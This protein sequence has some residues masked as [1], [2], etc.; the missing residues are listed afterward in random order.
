MATEERASTGIP[1]L[2]AMAEGGWIRGGTTVVLGAAG[3][4]KTLLGLHFIVEGARRDEKGVIV[5]FYE[6]PERLFRGAA[7]AGLDLE[8][9]VKRGMVEV[10]WHPR[11]E[12]LIDKV[13]ADLLGAVRRTKA[14][15]LFVDSLGAFA[16]AALHPER[17]S[18]FFASLATD[19]RSAGVTAVWTD[20]THEPQGPDILMG[21]DDASALS[22]NLVLLRCIDTPRG[23]Q[24]L[25]SLK[26]VRGS[27]FDSSMHEMWITGEGI[28]VA[29]TPQS[30]IDLLE[31]RGPMKTNVPG[32]ASEPP[33]G[34][35]AMT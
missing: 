5:T 21:V 1:E 35:G 33:M 20:E 7:V 2:D 11:R 3:S 25:V 9:Q 22:D 34:G 8:A 30:A 14:Q 17:M 10:L 15:R 29:A 18:D 19:L 28:R 13:G 24:R 27:S 31:G 12:Q 4:G 26:K 16:H 6:P 32:H 23:I